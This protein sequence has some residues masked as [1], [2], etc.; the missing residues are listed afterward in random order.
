MDKV[1]QLGLHLQKFGANLKLVAEQVGK[2]S[3]Q[4]PV[5][6][7]VAKILVEKGIVTQEEIDAEFQLPED[8][9]RLPSSL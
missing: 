2:L 9:E 5:L 6:L 8:A 7:V 3:H 4:I 1:D